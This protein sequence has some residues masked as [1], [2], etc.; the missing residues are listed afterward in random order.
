MII[1]F[2][3]QAFTVFL[4]WI[5]LILPTSALPTQISDG[6]TLIVGLM[7]AWSFIFPVAT[8]FEVLGVAMLFHGALLLWRL[9]HMVASYVRG[10]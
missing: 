3:L 8:L 4:S 1:G 5:A 10:N 2:L 9:A 7:N 6:V